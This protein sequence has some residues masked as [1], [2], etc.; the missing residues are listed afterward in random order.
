MTDRFEQQPIRVLV[1][2]PSA[3]AR[4]GLAALVAGSPA[5]QVVGR[6]AGRGT[7][8]RDVEALQPDVIVAQIDSPAERIPAELQ[9]LVENRE[10]GPAPAVVVLMDPDSS[11]RGLAADILRRGVRGLLPLETVGSE[12]TRTAEAVAAGLLVV[13]PAFLDGL[14]ELVPVL[15]DA[16]RS[17]PSLTAREIEVLNLIAHGLGNKEIA[18]QLG[19]S[20]HTVKFHIGSIFNKLDASS[21]AEAV[22]LGIRAGLILL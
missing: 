5:V 10:K 17:Q 22:T 14:S 9:A 1:V 8:A 7:L 11:E 3:V 18:D 6:S 19:I 2:A 15:R 21:R 20:E 4:E 12:I 16:A 13:H